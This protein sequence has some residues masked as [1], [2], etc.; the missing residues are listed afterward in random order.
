[1]S[2]ETDIQGLEAGKNGLP[3]RARALGFER[4]GM[5]VDPERAAAGLAGL[6]DD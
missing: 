6:P 5:S 3:V 2:A 1:M 4:P